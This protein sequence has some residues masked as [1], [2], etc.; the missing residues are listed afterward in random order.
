LFAGTNCFLKK[1][2]SAIFA[3]IVIYLGCIM[4]ESETDR[5]NMRVIIITAKM[6]SGRKLTAAELEFLK[7]RFLHER[8]GELPGARAAGK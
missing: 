7:S 5:R 8:T 2:S 4:R 3:E 1:K 6:E